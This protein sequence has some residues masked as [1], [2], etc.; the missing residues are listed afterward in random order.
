MLNS[1]AERQRLRRHFEPRWSAYQPNWPDASHK[2]QTQPDFFRS[3]S[4]AVTGSG[5]AFNQ[6]PSPQAVIFNMS[7]AAQGAVLVPQQEGEV[8]RHGNEANQQQVSQAKA[9]H[10][11]V[12]QSQA[13]LEEIVKRV[14]AQNTTQVSQIKGGKSARKKS[15]TTVSSWS[16]SEPD[17]SDSS[18]HIKK[19]QKLKHVHKHKSRGS[20]S[21]KSNIVLKDPWL[22]ET[23]ESSES[24]REEGELSGEQ[25]LDE[26]ES[27]DR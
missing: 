13:Q 4:S 25:E 9:Q 17:S 1:R 7:E 15:P 19:R 5:V 10:G 18:V 11:F 20:K 21:I 26:E 14:M 22:S 2:Q 24:S 23:P 6:L 16:D 27:S 8:E 3:L 12:I